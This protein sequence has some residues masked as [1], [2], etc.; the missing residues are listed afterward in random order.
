MKF[1]DSPVIELQVRDSHLS[2]QQDNGSFHVGTSVWPCSLVLAKFVERW[3]PPSPATT[4]ANNP[5]SE[6]LDFHSFR[7]RAIELGTGCG[8]AGMAFHLLGLQDIILTDISPVMPALKHNL[9]R[10]KPILGKNLKTSVLYWNNKDQ[11]RTANPPFDLVI[12]ADVVYIEESVGHLVGAMEALVA[13]DGAVLLG[14]QLRSPE[15]DQLFWEM[16]ENVFVIDKVPHQDLHPD[17]AYEET[18]VYV[19]RKKKNSN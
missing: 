16:C 19:F 13:D 9:K 11:I 18:D 6:L 2:I 7:R 15:A 4:G 17:Y 8:A 12:A 14:Y 1:T 3:A 10:N 5:Y